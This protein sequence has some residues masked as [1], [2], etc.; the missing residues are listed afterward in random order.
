M[1]SILDQLDTYY[2]SKRSAAAGESVSAP[3]SLRHPN[4]DEFFQNLMNRQRTGTANA[5]NTMRHEREQADM[6][7]SAYIS[8]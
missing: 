1:T 8:A 3:A 5:N 7:Q 6:Y 4:V 2:A